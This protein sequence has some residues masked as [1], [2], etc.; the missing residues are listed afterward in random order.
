MSG[1]LVAGTIEIGGHL[2]AGSMAE[3]IFKALD[4][5]LPV[6]SAE[7]PVPRQWFAV[8]IA[9]GVIA[10]LRDNAQAFDVDVRDSG[11]PPITRSIQIHSD[12]VTP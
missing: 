7:D 10:H 9:E 1:K 8:A 11:G 6:H 12:V 3:S 2:T 5:H 4:T